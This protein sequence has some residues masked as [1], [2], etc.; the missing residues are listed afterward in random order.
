MFD[1]MKGLAGRAKEAL[2]AT[3]A[4][5]KDFIEGEDGRATVEAIK[6]TATS[7]G[8]GAVQL[9]KDAVQSDLAKDAVSGAAIGAI[10]AVPVPIVGP[11]VGATVGAGLGVYKNLTKPGQP[12][13]IILPQKEKV[14]I[15]G[16]MLKVEDLRQKGI[17]TDEEFAD[18]KKRLLS[19]HQ[20]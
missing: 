18:M 16:E 1:K 9:G 3:A 12:P 8:N 13:Q 2:S 11:V 10:V 7:V 19:D 4:S 17:L 20:S 14:D 6:K 5:V 15:Y